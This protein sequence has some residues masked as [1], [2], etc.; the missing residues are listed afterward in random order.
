MARRKTPA[1]PA[2]SSAVIIPFPAYRQA[3]DARIG[4]LRD[5]PDFNAGFEFAMTLVKSLRDRGVLAR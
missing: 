3:P 5:N 2:T 1:A 4:R